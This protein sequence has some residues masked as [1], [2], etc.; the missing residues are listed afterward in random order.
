MEFLMGSTRFVSNPLCYAIAGGHWECLQYL[1]DHTPFSVLANTPL[2]MTT[3]QTHSHR[4]YPLHEMTPLA[5]AA[6]WNPSDPFLVITH[7]STIQTL[8]TTLTLFYS[9][10]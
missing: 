10:S 6:A 9:K 2:T 3:T 7:S 4:H 5:M 1:M 8:G